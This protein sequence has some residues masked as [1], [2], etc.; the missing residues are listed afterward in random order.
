M[1]SSFFTL[2]SHL[3]SSLILPSLCSGTSHIFPLPHSIM[4]N[5]NQSVPGTKETVTSEP[6]SPSPEQYRIRTTPLMGFMN[7]ADMLNRK[8]RKLRES[9]ALEEDQQRVRSNPFRLRCVTAKVQQARKRIQHQHSRQATQFVTLAASSAAPSDLGDGETGKAPARSRSC[10]RLEDALNSEAPSHLC[11]YPH[12]HDH[13]TSCP[14]LGEHQHVPPK[15]KLPP[16]V[17]G[18]T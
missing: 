3:F 10:G 16:R 12:P 7:T 9:V 15:K 8:K 14:K 2:T 5:S 4:R 6:Y 11:D 17:K 1:V 13:D 18:E